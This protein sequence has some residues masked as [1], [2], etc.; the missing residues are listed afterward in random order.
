METLL[1]VG[2]IIFKNLSKV[3]IDEVYKSK[4]V[5]FSDNY[6][7]TRKYINFKSLEKFR[8]IVEKKIKI[9]KNILNDVNKIYKKDFKNK[10][11]IGI[12]LRGSDMKST[13][14][15]PFPPTLR[16][17]INI[18][19]NLLKDDYDKVFLVTEEYKYLSK[20]KKIYKDK[21]IY[22][23]SFRTKDNKIFSHDKK[24]LYTDID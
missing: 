16:Q 15:H 10:K 23:N 9:K 5:C 20:L 11:I 18:I 19:N 22:L 3:K 7:D 14:N 24:G 6:L 17:S 2:N 12:H 13:P 1:I 21:L 4:N 8:K